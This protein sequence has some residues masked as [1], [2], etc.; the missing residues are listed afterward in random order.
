VPEDRKKANVTPAF[1]KGKKEDTE[2]YRWVSLTLI[3]GK[4][5]EHLILET[6]SRHVNNRKILR[7]SQH[8]FKKTHSCL[9]NLISFCDKMT[10]LVHE[11][12]AVDIV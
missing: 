7:S 4:V 12:R 9:T 10:S 3:P 6:I 8:G 2:N 5:M 1:K 11:R